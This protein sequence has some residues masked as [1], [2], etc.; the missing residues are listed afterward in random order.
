MSKWI[1]EKFGEIAELVYGKSLPKHSRVDGMVPVY[2]SN[3]IVGYHNEAIV[4]QAGIIVGRKGSAGCINFSKVPFCPIDT[5]FYI[6]QDTTKLDLEFL[7]FALEKLDLTRILGDVGVPGL[8]REMAYLEKIH[9]P[10]DRS[11]QRK[12]AHVLNL[13]QTSIEQQD[14]LIKTTTEL[15][16]AL[17]QKLFTEGTKGE[18]QKQTEIGLVPESWKKISIGELG[19]CVTGTTP[20]TSEEKYWNSLDFDFISPGDIGEKP[21]VLESQ[22]KLSHSGLEVCRILPSDSVMCVCIGSSI[23]KVA[24]TSKEKSATNQQIN[25]IICNSNYTPFYIYCLMTYLA[26]YWRKHA[27]FGP[28]PILN[29]SVFESIKIYV[30]NDSDEQL[31]IS[32]SLKSLD[33]KIIYHDKKKE[34]LKDL[35]KT[36]LH[37]L[38]TGQRRVHE[39]DFGDLE[40]E[41]AAN[42]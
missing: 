37:E 10:L 12:I 5:T 28:V 2:G 23:G 33:K 31:K 14:K 1:S 36:L 20:K 30:T 4:D 18:K 13:V 38:M 17:M 15:K 7:R 32:D 27:T 42:G 26:E 9:F 8:N 21:F 35:F 24:L 39:I 40:K 25:S 16:K 34:I 22:K 6:T 3:G 19:K 11:E 29:K 41:V